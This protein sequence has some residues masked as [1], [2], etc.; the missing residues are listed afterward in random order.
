MKTFPMIYTYQQIPPCTVLRIDVN[1]G[2]PMQSKE[3]V[4][5]LITFRCR[6]NVREKM[7]KS[8]KMIRKSYRDRR[9]EKSELE[10][11]VSEKAQFNLYTIDDSLIG[12]VY[13]EEKM[14]KEI[15][16]ED[17]AMSTPLDSWILIHST[18]NLCP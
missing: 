3:R 15:E 9:V 17:V 2:I 6:V 13:E 12:P 18:A 10:K 7:R 14:M 11:Q 1:S 4:P 8:Q 16:N 5:I